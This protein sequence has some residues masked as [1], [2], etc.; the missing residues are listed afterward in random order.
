MRDDDMGKVDRRQSKDTVKH[1]LASDSTTL[2]GLAVERV[3]LINYDSDSDASDTTI[4]SNTHTQHSKGMFGKGAS[5]SL[6]S[7]KEMQEL[8]ELWEIE[9]EVSDGEIDIDDDENEDDSIN[10]STIKKQS[11]PLINSSIIKAVPQ[12]KA[13]VK[14]AISSAIDAVLLLEAQT[15]TADDLGENSLKRAG[16]I[17]MDMDETSLNE[18]SIGEDST[19]SLPTS[20]P[21]ATH[22]QSSHHPFQQH[23]E[24]A[25]NKVSGEDIESATSVAETVPLKNGNRRYSSLTLREPNRRGSSLSVEEAHLTVIKQ[26]PVLPSFKTILVYDGVVSSLSTPFDV[27]KETFLK[28]KLRDSQLI[29]SQDQIL[30]PDSLL[31]QEKSGYSKNLYSDKRSD[32]IGPS[33]AELLSQNTSLFDQNSVNTFAMPRIQIPTPKEPDLEK[34]R[35]LALHKKGIIKIQFARSPRKDSLQGKALGKD[36]GI[37]SF[38]VD[39]PFSQD[40]NV[41]IDCLS[42]DE[43]DIDS[44][45]RSTLNFSSTRKPL[46]PSNNPRSNRRHTLDTHRNV[47]RS[48]EA[49]LRSRSVKPNASGS[50]VSKQSRSLSIDRRSSKEHDDHEKKRASIDS[51][52]ALLISTSNEKFT[53]QQPTKLS[54]ISKDKKSQ[55]LIDDSTVES[56]TDSIVESSKEQIFHVSN[57]QEC[58]TVDP[59]DEIYQGSATSTPNAKN[60]VQTNQSFTGSII[61]SEPM[62]FADEEDYAT[63]KEEEIVEIGHHTIVQKLTS[64]FETIS[65]KLISTDSALNYDLRATTPRAIIPPITDEMPYDLQ[66]FLSDE[67]EKLE[68]CK[69]GMEQHLRRKLRIGNNRVALKPTSFL[70]ENLPEH[71]D[72]SPTREPITDSLSRESTI[73]SPAAT[74]KL[75]RIK[76]DQISTAEIAPIKHGHY[77]AIKNKFTFDEGKLEDRVEE[78]QRQF[79]SDIGLKYEAIFGN[80]SLLLSAGQSPQRSNNHS[81]ERRESILKKARLA[82]LIE[83]SSVLGHYGNIGLPT[84]ATQDKYFSKG[85]PKRKVVFNDDVA[86]AL[87]PEKDLNTPTFLQD[88]GITVKGVSGIQ[89]LHEDSLLLKYHM[90]NYFDHMINSLY[91]RRI[92]DESLTE[93]TADRILKIVR[94]IQVGTLQNSRRSNRRRRTRTLCDFP[95]S[96]YHTSGRM[97]NSSANRARSANATSK[98]SSL[99]IRTLTGYTRYDDGVRVTNFK[100][101]RETKSPQPLSDSLNNNNWNWLTSLQGDAGELKSKENIFDVVREVVEGMV[102]DVVSAESYYQE[103]QFEDSIDTSCSAKAYHYLPSSA[104]TDRPKS[105]QLA[106][107]ISVE[108]HPIVETQRPETEHKDSEWYVRAIHSPHHLGTDFEDNNKGA[109]GHGMWTTTTIY[110]NE[111]QG[112]PRKL[113]MPKVVGLEAFSER[114]REMERSKV[115]LRYPVRNISLRI[116]KES[117]KGEES[118]GN[119]RSSNRGV[120]KGVADAERWKILTS[121]SPAVHEY[122]KKNEVIHRH[123][124]VVDAELG[125]GSSMVD[126]FFINREVLANREQCEM[127]ENSEDVDMMTKYINI[128]KKNIGTGFDS[129]LKLSLNSG[130]A[131]LHDSASVSPRVYSEKAS[132]IN[133]FEKTT[134]NVDE[135]PGK[136]KMISLLA[137]TAAAA[138]EKISTRQKKKKASMIVHVPPASSIS[139]TKEATA[140]S[141]SNNNSRPSTANSKQV[142]HSKQSTPAEGGVSSMSTNSPRVGIHLSRPA[143]P[144]KTVTFNFENPK[145]PVIK[146]MSSRDSFSK[147]R[148]VVTKK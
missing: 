134:D 24:V 72:D 54:T 63:E 83:Q 27:F 37:V 105:N 5:I 69:D 144:V 75:V 26:H 38:H 77:D 19:F 46:P 140:P 21:I 84:T 143:S 108:Y 148:R 117:T 53:Q 135:G 50:P 99:A 141:Q 70:P 130:S 10:S 109:E 42:D 16:S 114:K 86:E 20:R 51:E 131:I 60:A 112:S 9:S 64:M 76:Q 139:A 128:Y 25:V 95:P 67:P 94:R 61:E 145:E 110:K 7:G 115:G 87:D 116:S 47:S 80:K 79:L 147:K 89:Q 111:K 126:A 122:L 65:A 88:S 48:D 36:P 113:Q 93:I 104:N 8:G 23:S 146:Q 12:S 71:R 118:D 91:E 3:A 81:R 58:F 31:K 124:T 123:R 11:K 132:K 44:T 35:P 6:M 127:S 49:R 73:H 78:L 34:S 14:A 121:D 39:V 125:I 32:Y 85:F 40:R 102:N 119:S 68:D 15:S 133:R 101:D 17:A 41:T 74:K 98:V 59:I 56:F 96:G 55:V 2:D 129:K 18:N 106:R 22:P 120:T 107:L 4:H 43:T 1:S 138:V 13:T 142:P 62:S 82:E 30:Q 28:K 92:V 100:L 136:T 90:D 57:K 52:Q 137:A 66:Y 45:K 29:T 97:Y 33:Y 103:N